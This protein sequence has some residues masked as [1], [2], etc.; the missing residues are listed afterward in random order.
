VQIPENRTLLI[1]FVAD[2]PGKWAIT[3]SVLERFDTGLWTWFE[4]T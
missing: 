3:S 1:A 4:V 2:N